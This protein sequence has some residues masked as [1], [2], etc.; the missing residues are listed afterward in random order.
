MKYPD[1]FNPDLSRMGTAESQMYNLVA[2]ELVT[3]VVRSSLG[4][5]GMSKVYID[6]LGEETITGHGGAFLRKVD[7]DHP[8]AKAMVDAVNTVD[9]HVGDGTTAAAIL[10]GALLLHAKKM[11]AMRI[12]TASIIS[13]YESGLEAALHDLENMRMYNGNDT[14]RD[15]TGNDMMC[16]YSILRRLVECCM[17]GSAILE[18][19]SGSNNGIVNGSSDYDARHTNSNHGMIDL[20]VDA[21]LC[22]TDAKTGLSHP[23]DVKIEEKQGNALQTELV[24]GTVID[25]PIDDDQMPRVIHDARILLVSESLERSRTKTESEI[26]ITK[27]AQMGGFLSQESE[28]VSNIVNSVISCGANVVIS[29][30]GIDAESQEALA[31]L[32]I[33]SIRRVKHNDIWWLEKSTGAVTCTNITNI[34]H[35]ELGHAE[36]VYERSVGGDKMIFVE[37][38][39]KRPGSVTLLLR[40]SSKPYL[41]EFHRDVLNALY[42]ARTFAESPYVVYGGGSCEAILAHGVR[43]RAL[44][45]S[46]KAQVALGMFADALETIPMALAENAGMQTLDALPEL[47]SA[48]CAACTCHKRANMMYNHSGDIQNGKGG[49]RTTCKPRIPTTWHGIDHATRTIRDMSPAGCNIIEPYGIKEQVLKSATE[50]A[51]AIL[52][53]DDVFV[54][55]LID[56]THCHIDGTVHAH[57][58]P[59]RNHNHWEQEGLEQRQM[60]H[61]Y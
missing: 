18:L 37:S 16:N 26:T 10:A 17:A 40:A 27:P 52:N 35:A 9:N 31:R 30:K 47:R 51:C 61:H 3:R 11:R 58:E 13:G 6:I 32:G 23:D 45:T 12:P 34:K 41:D 29:R 39:L 50:A 33:M 2:G 4:P 55:D 15:D 43:A 21:I 53:V 24:R 5:R 54:K 8:A 60:H 25:K 22:T 7:V 19:T 46:G 14:G 42:M 28:N 48:T 1:L 56:N 44:D 20:V 36:R 49:S 38:G 57:K 59:G